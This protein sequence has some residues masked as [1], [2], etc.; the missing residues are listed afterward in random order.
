MEIIRGSCRFEKS[1]E[2]KRGS[3]AATTV[4]TTNVEIEMQQVREYFKRMEEK[5]S[6]V[7]LS[8]SAE[9]NWSKLRKK[10]SFIK[11]IA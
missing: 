2:E 9:K 7:K 1:K 8:P 4:E 10:L 5:N 6:N 3:A 11:L